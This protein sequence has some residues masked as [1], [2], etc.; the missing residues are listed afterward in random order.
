[1]TDSRIIQPGSNLVLPE[2]AK[3]ED[4]EQHGPFSVGELKPW[5]GLVFKVALIKRNSAGAFML[6][7]GPIGLS[8]GQIKRMSGTK[9]KA[10]T[11]AQK[12][13]RRRGVSSS[14]GSVL[15]SRGAGATTHSRPQT[16]P[17][18]RKV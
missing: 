9:G 18:A 6:V 15:Q 13:A 2:S 8:A 16:V 12:K 11:K 17:N 4:V 10:N 7:L 1:M 5:K 3:F 14:H